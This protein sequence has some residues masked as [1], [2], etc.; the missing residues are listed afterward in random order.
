MR[1]KLYY[2]ILWVL[3]YQAYSAKAQITSSTADAILPASY[4]KI[5][6][7]AKDTIIA[8]DTLF[9]MQDTVYATYDSIESSYFLLEDTLYTNDTT[10]YTKGHFDTLSQNGDSIFYIYSTDTMYF[11]LSRSDTALTD[12]IFI[13]NL[14]SGSTEQNIGTLA[15]S[16]PNPAKN[17]D[18]T[19]SKYNAGVF[20]N[21]HT[22]AGVEQSALNNLEEGGYRI[23]ITNTGYN[24]TS[25]YAWV[26]VNDMYLSLDTMKSN[27]EDTIRVELRDCGRITFIGDAAEETFTY[28]DVHTDTAIT[29]NNGIEYE[30]T[31]DNNKVTIKNPDRLKPSSI[32]DP[33]YEDTWFYLHGIDSFGCQRRDSVFYRSIVTKAKFIAHFREN[34]LIAEY[35]QEQS[36]YQE[37]QDSEGDSLKGAGPLKVLF[38]DSSL[39]AAKYEWVFDDPYEVKF[40]KSEIGNT[41]IDYDTSHIYYV[42]DQY[43]TTLITESLQFCTDTFRLFNPI[44]VMH[45]KIQVPNFFSPNGDNINDQFLIYAPSINSINLRIYNRWGNKIYQYEGNLENWEGWNGN[46]K[47]SNREAEPGIYYYVVQAVGWERNPPRNFEGKKYTGFFHLY[48]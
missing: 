21:F 25:L 37:Y 4:S 13:F 33:P 31:S 42:P 10:F 5:V 23:D 29:L 14:P 15:A 6:I 1:F 2:I 43:N 35:D 22:D 40:D 39:N 32:F 45:S 16:I 3:F 20:N 19:W 26:F 8:K 7:E 46:I 38:V 48:K 36:T 12:S 28:Y 11:Y 18:F 24:D 9:I 27:R 41:S 47:D 34:E 44:V 30:W 17:G